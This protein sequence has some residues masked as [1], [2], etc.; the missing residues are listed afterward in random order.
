MAQYGDPDDFNEWATIIGDK[1]WAWDNLNKYFRK[2]EHFQPHPDCPQVN[3][4]LHGKDGPVKIGFFNTAS[5]FPKAFIKGC[6]NVGIPFTYDFNTTAG[7]VGAGRIMTYIDEKRQRVSA[8]SAYLTQDV[9]ARSNLKVIVHA[10]VTRVLFENTQS[11]LRASGVEFSSS[12]DG[13]RY[14]ALARRDVIISAGAVHSPHVLKLSGI[15]PAE[16]LKKHG[17]P[18]VLDLPGVGSNLLDHPCIHLSFKD[19]QGLSLSYLLSSNVSE[20]VRTMF[21]VFRY[22]VGFGGPIATNFGE[23]AAFIRSDHPDVFPRRR[24]PERLPD[25][26]SG[27]RAPDLELYATP[28]GFEVGTLW[29]VHTLGLHCYLLRPSSHGEVLLKSANPWDLPSVDPQ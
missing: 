20:A 9:L 5:E 14:R 10:T 3:P 29:D 6:V 16:E 23:A 13:P 8:E 28:V 2:F 17:I 4:D 21:S 22:L 27:P 1:S 24:Y 26:T 7:T 11:G 19:S 15:G 18:V 12:A 25:S